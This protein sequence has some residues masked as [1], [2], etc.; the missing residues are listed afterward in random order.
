MKSR[1]KHWDTIFS[2]TEDSELWWYE[3]D[4][5]QTMKLL[6]YIPDL[7]G[8]SIFL[9]GV[10]TSILIDELLGKGANLVLNDISAE[11][12]E[13]VKR[14]LKGGG[15]GIKWL[16]QDISLPIPKKVPNIDIWIDRAVLHFLTDRDDIKGYFDNVKSM[17]NIGG[18][19]I[20]AEF[21]KA[22]ASKCA[23]LDLHQYSI[24]E[25]SNELGSSFELI[26]YFD[27]VY[28]NPRGDPRPY[29]YSL[30]KRGE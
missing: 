12:L 15:E 3:N 30:Y 19:A 13:S 29:L 14:R 24:E 2:T 27:F 28:T 23:G 25:L 6:D 26:S 9:P 1:S 7:E 22:G 8:L 16:C 4:I 5:S 20:F 10:G 21:S 18:Y 11:A 17:L